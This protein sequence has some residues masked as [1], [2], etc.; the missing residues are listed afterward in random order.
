MSK[1]ATLAV[2]STPFGL[3]RWPR[4]VPSP[5]PGH[6]KPLFSDKDSSTLNRLFNKGG[7]PPLW[8]PAW[9]LRTEDAGV[10]LFVLLVFF[11]LLFFLFGFGG[12]LLVVVSLLLTFTHDSF[13]LDSDS[14]LK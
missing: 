12:F 1:Q 2:C 6:G 9:Q 3:A 8:V 13:S 14:T 4:S 5:H 7:A 11:R 10:V